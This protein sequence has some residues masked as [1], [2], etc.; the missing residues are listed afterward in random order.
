MGIYSVGVR[1]AEERIG[2]TI[3]LVFIT[4]R[5]TLSN[6]I[7]LPSSDSVKRFAQDL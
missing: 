5:S 2:W 3:D 7:I 1:V 4:Q 6:A